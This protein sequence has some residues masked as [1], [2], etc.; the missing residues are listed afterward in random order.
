MAHAAR[1]SRVD[2][3]VYMPSEGVEISEQWDMSSSPNSGICRVLRT[4]GYVES[5]EQWDMS[6]PPNSGI[7][8]KKTQRA[9][10]AG[11]KADANGLL[12]MC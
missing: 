6:S 12:L 2:V 4:V 7:C 5:S 8:R 9:E 11:A 10:E 1:A 3:E